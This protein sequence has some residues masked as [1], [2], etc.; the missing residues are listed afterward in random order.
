MTPERVKRLKKH[1]FVALGILYLHSNQRITVSSPAGPG[2]IKQLKIKWD[3]LQ[4]FPVYGRIS[5]YS[6]CVSYTH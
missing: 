2:C 5:L 3:I 4:P 6:F 1:T